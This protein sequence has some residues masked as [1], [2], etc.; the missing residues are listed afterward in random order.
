MKNEF[1]V[2]KV[3]KT[4]RA[5]QS[6]QFNPLNRLRNKNYPLIL[7]DIMCENQNKRCA[8]SVYNQL[9]LLDN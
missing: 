2:N 3:F 4:E 8:R 1:I 6:K 9:K 5:R 7:S